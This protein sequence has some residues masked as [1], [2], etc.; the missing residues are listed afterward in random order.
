MGCC[1]SQERIGTRMNHKDLKALK[2][3]YDALQGV[4]DSPEGNKSTFSRE[5]FIQCFSPLRAIPGRL[6]SHMCDQSETELA[7]YQDLIRLTEMILTSK[8]GSQS[9]KKKCSKL[10]LLILLYFGAED[11]NQEIILSR[12]EADCFLQVSSIFTFRKL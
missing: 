9:N 8:I 2:E 1:N 12:E 6:Y 3:A 4:P 10:E 7:N 5:A 11:K